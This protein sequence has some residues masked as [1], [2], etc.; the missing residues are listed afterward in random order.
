MKSICLLLLF[1]APAA[2]AR[3]ALPSLTDL[4]L[5]PV[6]DE[7]YDAENRAAGK[8]HISVICERAT[9]ILWFICHLQPA[10]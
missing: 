5:P 2:W 8:Y 3:V 1:V 4:E 7:I 10:R 9:F 6:I